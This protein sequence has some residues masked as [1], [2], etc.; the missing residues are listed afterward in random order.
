MAADPYRMAKLVIDGPMWRSEN[1][2]RSLAHFFVLHAC[3]RTT[4]VSEAYKAT[5]CCVAHK[6]TL[7]LA[8]LSRSLLLSLSLSLSPFLTTSPGGF[9]PCLSLSDSLSVR[10][11]CV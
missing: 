5:C 2:R 4:Q 8:L 11:V 10:V 9:L 6:L 1:M 7:S 3:F